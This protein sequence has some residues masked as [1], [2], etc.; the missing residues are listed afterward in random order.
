MKQSISWINISHNNSFPSPI[1]AI[2][3]VKSGEKIL[4]S[5]ADLAFSSAIPILGVQENSAGIA[6]DEYVHAG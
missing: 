3:R 1:F 6:Y 4:K 2:V 5:G